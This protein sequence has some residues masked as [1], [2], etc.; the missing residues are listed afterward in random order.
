MNVPWLQL[1]LENGAEIFAVRNQV[2]GGVA[3]F[4][5]DHLCSIVKML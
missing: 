1:N 2:G 5:G 4:D 3:A